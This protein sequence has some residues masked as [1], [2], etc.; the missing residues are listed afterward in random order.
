[1]ML[2]TSVPVD[3]TFDPRFLSFVRA[4]MHLKGVLIPL[5]FDLL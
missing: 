5:T 4:K 1:M 3:H 2:F